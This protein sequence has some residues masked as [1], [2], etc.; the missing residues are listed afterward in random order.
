M[1]F[2]TKLVLKEGRPIQHQQKIALMGSCFSDSIGQKLSDSGFQVLVNPF[3][4]LYNPMSISR[5][6]KKIISQEN[7]KAEEIKEHQQRYFHFDHHTS[8]SS[9][10]LE[11]VLSSIQTNLESTREFVQ[12]LDLLI[13]TP[14]SAF[15]YESIDEK[16]IV[17]NCHKLPDHRF[18]RRMLNIQ[19][20]VADFQSLYPKLKEK[21]PD[22]RVIFTVSPVR[23]W[24]HGAHGNQLS[25]ATLLLA[26]DEIQRIFPEVEY[27][28]SYELLIDELRDYRFY[29]EDMLHPGTQT[30]EYIY[31]CFSKVYFDD[32]TQ[33]LAKQAENINQA[34]RHQVFFKGSKTH[35]DFVSQQ[36]KRIRSLCESSTGI[37]LKR[38]ENI[39]LS[40]LE[41]IRKLT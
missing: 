21:L 35:V 15:V 33:N 8:F 5:N 31:E 16:T 28:P 40:Q 6:L 10:S 29:S 32:S 34:S 7:Y 22:L 17:A 2:R 11:Q 26:I 19:E 37:N 1:E 18:S 13:I 12:N 27:F 39:F 24:K 23:H 38:A 14:G 30:V 20:I 36:L 3:G 41:E 9:H 25:K 4:V